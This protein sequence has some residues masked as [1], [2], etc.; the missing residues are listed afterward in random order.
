MYSPEK[1]LHVKAMWIIY[2][3]LFCTATQL[4]ALP[5][6]VS[7]YI[8]IKILIAN[9]GLVMLNNAKGK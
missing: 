3:K 4:V 7:G 9:L 5:N 1:I 6:S 2:N 8:V